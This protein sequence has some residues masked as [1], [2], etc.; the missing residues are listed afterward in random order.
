MTFR[1]RT[2]E[3]FEN[4]FMAEYLRAPAHIDHNM[5]DLVQWEHP[6]NYGEIGVGSGAEKNKMWNISISPK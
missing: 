6:Q 3:Y 5:G 2:L 1:Y 4:N